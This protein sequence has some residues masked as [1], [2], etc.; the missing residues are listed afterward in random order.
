[1]ATRISQHNLSIVAKFGEWIK[2]D[3]AVFDALVTALL[4]ASAAIYLIEN[5]KSLTQT[6]G[7]EIVTRKRDKS[8]PSCP[9]SMRRVLGSGHPTDCKTYLLRSPR[10]PSLLPALVNE[11]GR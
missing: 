5:E 7:F 6:R 9:K 3:I 8:L 2:L 10:T 4:S 1:M 11:L